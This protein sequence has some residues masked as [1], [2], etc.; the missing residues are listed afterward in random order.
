MKN[1]HGRWKESVAVLDEKIIK[2]SGD[3]FIASAGV[4]YYGPF[5]GVYRD[6][7]V[8]KWIQY[9]EELE[10]PASER[11]AMSEVLGDPMEI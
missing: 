10:I 3:V 1:E 4:S 5:T 7:L 2:L 9:C 8:D 11:F 6:R